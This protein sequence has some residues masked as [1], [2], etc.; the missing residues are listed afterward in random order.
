MAGPKQRRELRKALL[1]FIEEHGENWPRALVLADVG[2]AG[3]IGKLRAIAW[4]EIWNWALS[5]E[6]QGR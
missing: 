1:D 5:F 6:E 3:A 4:D 2:A